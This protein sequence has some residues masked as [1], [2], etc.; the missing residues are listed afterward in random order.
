[1]TNSCFQSPPLEPSHGDEAV[2]KAAAVCRAAA[3]GD[4]E[5]R[6]IQLPEDKQIAELMMAVNALLDATD[7]FVRESSASLHAASEGRFYRKFILRGQP[8]AFRRSAQAI[9]EASSEIDKQ[10]KALEETR[11]FRAQVVRELE[12]LMQDSADRIEGVV[13][14]INKIMNGIKVLALNALIEA[15]RAGEA[16]R[17]F[18]VVA[19][20][21]KNMAEQIGVSMTGIKSELTEFR[22]EAGR[23]IEVIAKE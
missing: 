22:T 18:A 9:N 10:N 15:A 19:G 21:V 14:Q 17:G 13:G 8:G 16:G 5:Q 4:L 23:V 1:M 2:A 3:A 20:E 11:Q 12:T 7:S 6:I